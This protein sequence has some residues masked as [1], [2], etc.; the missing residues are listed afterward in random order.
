M[1]RY[2]GKVRLGAASEY[3]ARVLARA[4]GWSLSASRAIVRPGLLVA[5]LIVLA[6]ICLVLTQSGLH[7]G[8]NTITVNTIADPGTATQCD[9]RDAITAANTNTTVNG[10]VVAGPGNDDIVFSLSGIITLAS[11][12]PAIANVS[13]NS[14]TIDGTGQTITINGNTVYQ[15]FYVNSGATLTLNDLTIEVSTA[16]TGGRDAPDGSGSAAAAVEP[17]SV[18]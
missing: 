18:R 13:P 1:K 4:A 12:L 5:L 11:S 17:L 9:L 15:I 2:A 7:A 8:V 14:L 6:P 16:A 3:L 10:C